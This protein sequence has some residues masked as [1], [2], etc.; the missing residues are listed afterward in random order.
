[1]GGRP[2]PEIEWVLRAVRF[3][4]ASAVSDNPNRDMSRAEGLNI[5]SAATIAHRLRE[6]GYITPFEKGVPAKLTPLAESILAEHNH[7]VEASEYVFFEMAVSARSKAE[8]LAEVWD[9]VMQLESWE[10]KDGPFKL[11]ESRMKNLGK[12]ERE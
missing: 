7:K 10:P 4:Q 11:Q 12:G 9:V 1:M 6:R 5:R 3:V 2:K 8:A